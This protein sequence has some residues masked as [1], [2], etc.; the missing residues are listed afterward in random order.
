MNFC[1]ETLGAA[2]GCLPLQMWGVPRA[3][4]RGGEV[5]LTLSA[6]GDDQTG[7]LGG[8]RPGATVAVWGDEPQHG[9]GSRGGVEGS[10]SLGAWGRM[11]GL[12]CP[13]SPPGP[14]S[15][16]CSWSR[17]WPICVSQLLKGLREHGAHDPCHVA[18]RARVCEG[19]GETRCVSHVWPQP[20]DEVGQ[21]P[22]ASGPKMQ[23]P[24]QQL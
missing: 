22:R 7:D 3:R 11:W 9:A 20:G 2:L 23:R 16:G 5:T 14:G 18:F 13:S 10:H 6:P 4:G 15:P 21:R 12:L 17:L 19:G 1:L 8:P 24:E